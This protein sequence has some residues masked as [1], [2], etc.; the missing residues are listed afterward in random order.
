M[1][2]SHFFT[3]SAVKQSPSLQKKDWFIVNAAWQPVQ[4]RKKVADKGTENRGQ[5]APFAK[6]MSRS[7]SLARFP[8]WSFYRE[9]KLPHMWAWVMAFHQT[10][11]KGELAHLMAEDCSQLR[12]PPPFFCCQPQ[13]LNA[14][15][16][17]ISS[18]SMSGLHEIIW[19]RTGIKS[20]QKYDQNGT[21]FLFQNCR[22]EKAAKTRQRCQGC[23]LAQK[24]Q[25]HT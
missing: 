3:P 11:N 24:H 23:H 2:P 6:N 7:S 8:Q 18:S 15:F 17:Q 1:D 4:G 14:H 5:G 20:M 10:P 22:M 21:Q 12:S 9:K 16:V 25:Q 13:Y 19:A